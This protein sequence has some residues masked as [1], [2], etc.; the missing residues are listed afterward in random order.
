LRVVVVDDHSSFRRAARVLLRSRGFHVV[1]EADC[2]ASAQHLVDALRPDGVLLDLRLGAECGL[3][4]ARA[5]TASRPQLSVILTSAD[6]RAPDEQQVA[7][8]GARTFIPKE[9][10]GLVDPA[11]VCARLAEMA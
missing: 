10:L 5:L 7:A 6:D 3:D 11:T 9:R 2:G 4:V 8:S 1:G